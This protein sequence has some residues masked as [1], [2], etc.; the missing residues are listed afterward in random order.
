M[1]TAKVITIAKTIPTITNRLFILKINPAQL[2]MD[3]HKIGARY[4][5]IL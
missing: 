5:I 4:G 2:K 3:S 1:I